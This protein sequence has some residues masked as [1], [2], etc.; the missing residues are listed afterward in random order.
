[1]VSSFIKQV[2]LQT[3]LKIGRDREHMTFFG[4]SFKLPLFLV[5]LLNFFIPLNIFYFF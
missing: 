4:I 3:S 1:M 2:R 5:F